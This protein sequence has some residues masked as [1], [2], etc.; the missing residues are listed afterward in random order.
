MNQQA[1]S[2]TWTYKL[3][4]SAHQK[5]QQLCGY[6]ANQG[7]KQQVYLNTLAVHAV[8]DYLNCMGW[9]TDLENSG[10]HDTLLSTLINL[11]DLE[12]KNYGKL[13]CLPVLANTEF[14][15]IS[16]EVWEDRIGHVVVQIDPDFKE[17][18][19]L[20]F[21][22]QVNRSLVP[23]NQLYPLEDLT[24]YLS[25]CRQQERQTIVNLS[26]WLENIF[27]PGWHSLENLLADSHQLAW[28]FR[29]GY[30]LVERGKHLE[31][32]GTEKSVNLCVGI[33]PTN[34]VQMDI[35]VEVYP[36]KQQKHLPEELQLTI[37]DEKGQSVMQAL[38]EKS[39]SL[40]FKFG[41]LPHETF[42]VKVA[43]GDIYTTE[44]FII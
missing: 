4:I 27:A 35:L 42:I 17:A 15:K 14:V 32:K 38:A 40:E 26:Q 19:L 44:Q 5:V 21:L 1:E 37:I 28:R 6:Q 25:Q 7:K 36:G 9:E 41:G 43:L 11:A 39:K 13:E 8:N 10:S 3:G 31:L 2:F 16:K 20:G 33:K 24:V 23:I 12:V 30:S 18:T 22:P 34:S 29:S